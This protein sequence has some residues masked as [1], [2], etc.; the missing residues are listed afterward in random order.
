MESLR[1]HDKLQVKAG[2]YFNQEVFGN[3]WGP[4]IG[5]DWKVSNRLQLYGTLPNNYKI[6]HAIKEK[7]WFTGLNFKAFTRSFQLLEERNNN[8]IRFDEI[9]LK[10]FIEYYGLKNFVIFLEG[11]R[12]FGNAPLLYQGGSRDLVSSASTNSTTKEYFLISLGCA[13]R[14]RSF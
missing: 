5:L 14:I 3:F 10:G 11:G 2:I 4:L 7:K 8:Y 1:L 9:V 12:A 6:E 13:F